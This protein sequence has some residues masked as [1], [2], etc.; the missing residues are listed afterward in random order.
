MRSRRALLGS[1]QTDLLALLPDSWRA[2]AT[3]LF[4]AWDGAVRASSLVENWHSVLRPHLAI[5]RTLSPGLLALL[6]V[7]H[8]HRRFARGMHAGH[9][10]LG[11]SGLTTVSTDWL[12]ALGYPPAPRPRPAPSSPGPITEGCL[13]A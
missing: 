10:P 6:A 4:T 13:V 12:V 3:A 5:H 8:N 11:L 1:T 7:W 9:S 2:P